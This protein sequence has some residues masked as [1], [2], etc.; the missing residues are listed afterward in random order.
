VARLTRYV[1]QGPCVILSP[2]AREQILPFPEDIGMGWGVEASWA[3]HADLRLGI[4]DA[5][6]LRHLKAVSPSG[7][8]VDAEW[9]RAL[10]LLAATG[11][12]T[13]ADL[14]KVSATWRAD[15]R[16]APWLVS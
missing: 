16:V 1:E 9:E 12:E 15:E 3:T 6:H 8:D 2:R 5:V 11:A 4:I 13:W 7:Y 14:Q 10:Q